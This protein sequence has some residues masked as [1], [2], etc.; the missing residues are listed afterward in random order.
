MS[1][2]PS[3]P[4]A[5]VPTLPEVVAVQ[6]APAAAADAAPAPAS[7]GDA[8]VE[9]PLDELR[10]R[11]DALFDERLRVALAPAFERLTDHL[12]AEVK[13]QLQPLLREALER[14]LRRDDTG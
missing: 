9:R 8:T 13:E 12:L 14:S 2:Q 4:P 5:R 6:T 11:I 1:A 3:P 10:P 7:A